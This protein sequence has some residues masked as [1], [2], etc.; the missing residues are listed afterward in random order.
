MITYENYLYI[1][2]RTYTENVYLRI[3]KKITRHD[4]RFRFGKGYWTIETAAKMA[5]IAGEMI[6]ENQVY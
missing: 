1:C 5:A 4:Q 6:Y 3:H 2:V